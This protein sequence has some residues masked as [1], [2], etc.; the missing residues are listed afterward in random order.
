MRFLTDLKF[1]KSEFREINKRGRLKITFKVISLEY[2]VKR[3]FH[4]LYTNTREV[5]YEE[6]SKEEIN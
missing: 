4:F 5:A 2:L 1:W 6:T 3:Q